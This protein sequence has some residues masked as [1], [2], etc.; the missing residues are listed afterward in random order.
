MTR[1]RVENAIAELGYQPNAIARAMA[2]GRTD[3]LACLSPNLTDFT[4]AS[5]IEG[6]EYEARQKGY[7]LLTAS[8]PDE[9]AFANLVDQLLASR[10]AEG[11]LVINPYADVRYTRLPPHTSTVFVGADPI[12]GLP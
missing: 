7:F 9:N 8:A 1:Q 11:L 4:F 6:A 12:A 2:Q 5:I 3:T 10:R